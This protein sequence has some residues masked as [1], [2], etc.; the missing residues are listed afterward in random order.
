MSA[1]GRLVRTTAFK[2][3]A[4]YLLVFT[5]FAACLL[6]YFFWNTQRLLGL[7]INGSIDAEVQALAEQYGQGGLA[8]LVT[9]IDRRSRQPGSLLY[10]VT[11]AAGDALA[12]NVAELPAMILDQPGW[13]QVPYARYAEPGTAGTMR[14][15]L[16]RVFSLSDGVR[17]LVGLDLEEEQRVHAV[18]ANATIWTA[19]L[20]LLMGLLGG[21]FVTRRVLRRLDG[22]VQTSRSIIAGD[23]SRRLA[24]T[25]SGDELD[26]LAASTN[27]MLDRIGEL[28]AGL[29]EV[30]DNIAHD[31]KTP[32]TRLRN[33]AEEALR[34]ERSA[35]GYR[36]ALEK[37]I[38]E[39][40]GLIRTFNALLLI[41]RVEAGN[42][43]GDEV[44]FDA[45][46]V[47]RDVAELYE[48]VAE[49][50][51]VPLRVETDGALPLRGNRELVG[52][53][54]ANLV[55]NALNHGEGAGAEVAVRAGRGTDGEVVIAVADRGAGIPEADRGRV[56]ERFVR[57]EA[58]RTRPG[59]GLGLSL[60]AAV[61]RI[62]G[63]Q[64]QLADNGP[65]LRAELHLPA[66]A[67]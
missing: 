23:L 60:V 3:M 24:V 9:V 61:A 35:E 2:L 5:L 12:G 13:H 56:L 54:V 45:A 51:G 64:L 26:R 52:Q 53:A 4:V 1:A 28:M 66:R 67:A 21:W 7:Q 42:L 43:G 36:Q 31:L 32:L 37:T 44:E 22:L 50:R 20:I 65:G 6:G 59:S 11:T 48:P 41:A 27:A 16:V 39:S 29:K 8:R 62:H 40:D 19:A 46:E 15:A 34:G 33:R 63:G 49:E 55:D 14:H 17:L 10:L 38:E 25:G 18:M 47:A 57:L 58:S 30:S